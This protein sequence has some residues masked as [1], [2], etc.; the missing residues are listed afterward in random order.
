MEPVGTCV[1]QE[2]C[3][4]WGMSAHPWLEVNADWII[5]ACRQFG[6][7][8]NLRLSY[9]FTFME[10]VLWFTLKKP[11]PLWVAKQNKTV[12]FWI[13]LC[14]NRHVFQSFVFFSVSF[15]NTFSSV[16]AK[17]TIMFAFTGRRCVNWNP[18]ELILLDLAIYF[19]WIIQL[20]SQ[21]KV[22]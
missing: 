15:V 13:N 10:N 7:L 8:L 9:C 1:I 20:D 12:Q 5:N 2:N 14:P 4:L 3:L 18:R 22:L 11:Y 17:I 6:V 16:W 21:T 19:S